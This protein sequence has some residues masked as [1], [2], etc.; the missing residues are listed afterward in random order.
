MLEG[1]DIMAHLLAPKPSKLTLPVFFNVDGVVGSMPAANIR[2]DVLLV[3]YFF[4]LIAAQPLIGF[5][6]R[7]S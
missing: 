2:E 7:I 4:T 6:N 5:G 3:Q 1:E